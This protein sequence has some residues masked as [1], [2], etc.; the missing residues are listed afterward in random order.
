[1]M[2]QWPPPP[3]VIR[4]LAR[5]AWYTRDFLVPTMCLFFASQASRWA[6]RYFE[7]AP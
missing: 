6:S 4:M 7:D 1:M 3:G 5:I 2:F